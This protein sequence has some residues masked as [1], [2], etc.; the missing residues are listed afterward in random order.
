MNLLALELGKIGKPLTYMTLAFLPSI[1]MC[2]DSGMVMGSVKA[3]NGK[4]IPGFPVIIERIGNGDE[5]TSGPMVT[6][7][8]EQGMFIAKKL[9]KGDYRA[10]VP[11]EID[12]DQIF[13]VDEP[14]PINTQGGI[15]PSINLPSFVVPFNWEASS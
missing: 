14:N 13:T 12:E 10:L 11:S 3:S 4:P 2:G 8:N 1:A 7:T 6:F 5:P 9:P 15:N